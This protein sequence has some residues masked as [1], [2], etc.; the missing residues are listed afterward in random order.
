[1]HPLAG[2]LRDVGD[3]LDQAVEHGAAAALRVLRLRARVWAQLL[4]GLAARPLQPVVQPAEQTSVSQRGPPWSPTRPSR[5]CCRTGACRAEQQKSKHL[6]LTKLTYRDS[7]CRWHRLH[8]RHLR[9]QSRTHTASI[10]GHRVRPSPVV[11]AD[12]LL[13][14][15]HLLPAGG[16]EGGVLRLVLQAPDRRHVLVRHRGAELRQLC[17]G[18]R[19]RAQLA[20]ASEAHADLHGLTGI[21]RRQ[22]LTSGRSL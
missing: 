3:L 7:L 9:G 6:K 12:V 16:P 20:T 18:T 11:R 19:G 17:G 4:D 2:R 1:M 15:L 10:R 13:V 22:E 5:A 14:L 21:A 8:M